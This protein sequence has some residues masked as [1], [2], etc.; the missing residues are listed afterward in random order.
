M[1]MLHPKREHKMCSMGVG[2]VWQFSSVL[3]LPRRKVRR[4]DG[5]KRAKAL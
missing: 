2:H 5:M 3:Q 4:R 1:G